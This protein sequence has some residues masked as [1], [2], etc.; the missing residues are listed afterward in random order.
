MAVLIG[1][2]V[3]DENG[4]IDKTGQSMVGDQTGKEICTRHFYIRTGGWHTY[5]Q[6]IDIGKGM[7]AARILKQICDDN[8]YGYSQG[9]RWTGYKAIVANGKRVEGA[10]GSFDCSSLVISSLI[11]AGFNLKPDGYTGN[12]VKKLMA[13]GEFTE[14]KSEDYTADDEHA[15]PGGVWVG[16][17]HTC[18]ALE[19]GSGSPTPVLGSYVEVVGRSVNIRSGAGKE[20]PKLKTAHKGDKLPY[21]ETDE[22]TGWY[23]IECSKGAGCITNKPK[24]TKLVLIE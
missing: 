12:L 16:E 4:S 21:I 5:L 14:H 2:A 9:A 11:L 13:S 8:H 24:Y 22:D 7:T 1:H 15:L 17:G 20:Y 18:M 10:E 23:W 3:M 19:A 6:P